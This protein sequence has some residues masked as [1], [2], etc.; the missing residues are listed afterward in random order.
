MHYAVAMGIVALVPA[1]VEEGAHLNEPNFLLHTGVIW[2]GTDGLD[3][4]H[5]CYLLFA[6]PFPTACMRAN[7][8][9]SAGR[10]HPATSRE[11]VRV[12]DGE[13]GTLASVHPTIHRF[14]LLELTPARR[15]ALGCSSKTRDTP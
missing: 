5:T 7:S 4:R 8:L 9:D 6:P 15:N 14:K 1:S 13:H 2:I 10:H 11:R 12:L 3:K